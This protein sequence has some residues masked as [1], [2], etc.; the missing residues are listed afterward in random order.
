MR[1]RLTSALALALLSVCPRPLAAQSPEPA[2]VTA[3]V[4]SNSEAA[5]FF[6]GRRGSFPG[7]PSC[8]VWSWVDYPRVQRDPL[9]VLL[10]DPLDLNQREDVSA[11]NFVAVGWGFECVTGQ[12]IDRIDVWYQDYDGIWRQVVQPPSA[13]RL[14][15]IDRPDVARFAPTVQCATPTRAT[16]WAMQISGVPPGLRR[17][18][19]E[20]WW[21]PYHERTEFTLLVKR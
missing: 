19:L 20:V 14:G 11:S 21:G 6:T 9:A 5:P 16:G 3:E 7:C 1:R 17:M 10:G 12:S 13:L 2:T 8:G 4:L 18:R 15:V